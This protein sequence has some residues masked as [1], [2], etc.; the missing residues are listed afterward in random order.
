[1]DFQG[2]INIIQKYLHRYS[3]SSIGLTDIVEIIIISV[4][5]YHMIKWLQLTRAWTLFKGITVLLLFALLAIVFQLDLALQALL[6]AQRPL[7][8]AFPPAALARDA[9]ADYSATWETKS[10]RGSATA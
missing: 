6:T 10:S 7:R 4:I 5:I 2:L 9:L 8:R 1:M 3:I